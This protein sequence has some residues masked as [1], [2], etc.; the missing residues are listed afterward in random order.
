MNEKIRTEELTDLLREMFSPSDYK[1]I[2]DLKLDPVPENSKYSSF[3]FSFNNLEVVYRKAKV[4]PD[5][6]GAFVTLWQRPSTPSVN[7]KPIPLNSSQ[8]NYIMIRVQKYADNL[9]QK[10]VVEEGLFIF[11]VALLVKRDIISSKES[12]GKTGFRVFPPWSG[13]RGNE[14]MKVF[15]ASGK[16]TQAWQ[17]PYFVEI[18]NNKKIDKMTLNKIF[19]L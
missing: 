13:D 4:T 11:P 3:N 10:G 1:L 8:L 12:K 6:P 15:S 2:S 5:R 16:K 19:N 14:G 7:N 17:L 9:D 18:D